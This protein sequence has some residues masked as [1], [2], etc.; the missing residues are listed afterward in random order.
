MEKRRQ[1]AYNKMQ[2]ERRRNGSGSDS[3]RT[4][5]NRKDMLDKKQPVSRKKKNGVGKTVAHVLAFAGVTLAAFLIVCFGLM[6]VLFKGPSPAMKKLF[7][8]SVEET[9]AMKWLA[10]LY[11]PQE[12][13][14]RIMA[15]KNTED[16]TTTDTGLIHITG[17]TSETA[18]EKSGTASSD[19]T[20]E[21]AVAEEKKDSTGSRAETAGQQDI[22]I[23][24]V[25]SASYRG[26]MMIVPDPSDIILGTPD[27]FGANAKGLILEDMVKKYGARAGINA[28]GFDDPGGNGKGGVPMGLVITDGKIRWG[29]AGTSYSIIG[30]DDS[31]RLRVGKM[32]G[33]Q[34]LNAK[35][36]YACS[37]GPALVIN[38]KA[39]A[40]TG[41]VKSGV[42]PRTAIGQREDGT[43]LM[44]VVDGRQVS[45]LGATFDD[46]T[47]IMLDY[48]AVNASNLDGGSSS[49]MILDGEI[50]NNCSSV[51]G[52]RYL[53][54]AFLV[55]PKGSR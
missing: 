35:V 18:A 4:E 6:Y 29:N 42:N 8:L 48:G 46:L 50:R 52:Q 23:E 26:Y 22:T 36:Q 44:L 2:P 38:G 13:I 16:R 39:E 12:E 49:T 32:T 11:L 45:S 5:K 30:F 14:D 7:T 43:V 37:F 47:N 17:S 19:L 21:N 55:L 53:A 51:I 54:S 9:S 25:K 34:A 1:T 41:S 27:T 10:N 33:E 28:G 40:N 15:V 31:H 20:K 24:Q 3:E